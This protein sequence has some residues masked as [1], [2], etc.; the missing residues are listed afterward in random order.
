M[1]R[2]LG[3]RVWALVAL[4]GVV[5]SA[6]WGRSHGWAL[7]LGGVLVAAGLGAQLALLGLAAGRRGLWTF[8]IRFI[9]GAML[10][11]AVGCWY[12]ANSPRLPGISGTAVALTLA[13]LWFA[14]GAPAA[15][16][17]ELQSRNLPGTTD[18]P[19]VTPH[20]PYGLAAVI[21]LGFLV[22][23]FA[24]AAVSLPAWAMLGLAVL[25]TLALVATGIDYQRLAAQ[26]H[27]TSRAL[28]QFA[29]VYAMPYNGYAS[30]H[31]GL[32]LPY[33]LRTGKPVVVVTTNP[34]AFERVAEHYAVPVIYTPQA[35]HRAAIRA[36]FPPSVRAAFYVHNGGNAEFLKIKNVTHVF[37]HHGDSDK[38]TSARPRT[39]AYDVLVVA[40]QAAIDRFAV[41]GI[42]VPSS[43][44]KVLGRPQIEEIHT[45]DHPIAAVEQPVV[46]Y[47]PTWQGASEE[48]NYSSLPI[49]AAIVRALLARN[50]TVVFRPHPA[51]RG[52]PDNAAAISAIN[53]L[54]AADAKATRRR[55]RWGKAADAPTVAELTNQVDAMVSDVSGMVTDFL[56]SLKPFAMVSTRLDTEQFRTRFPSSQAAYVI[57]GDLSTLDSALDAM[58]GDDPLAAVRAE[59]RRYYLGGFEDGESARAFIRYAES[60]ASESAAVASARM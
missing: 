48:V 38:E 21:F 45:V 25:A 36:M 46:L 13:A 8:W 51:G 4:A 39:V 18:R 17:F 26:N 11:L 2:W 28:R 31:I 44:F 12:W 32:W 52:N 55:H 50:A 33:L 24:A 23:S 54:L 41:R 34:V 42:P 47:A 49:G 20:W 59:R 6:G 15:T 30:F 58:L 22:L 37:V 35:Q 1:Q 53:A 14:R 29:P 40:G 43:K 3:S 56:Q 10:T 7:V 16:G 60:L 57:E 5:I 19:G 9:P 27:S